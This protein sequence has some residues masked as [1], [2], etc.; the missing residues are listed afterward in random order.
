MAVALGLLG[1]S[2]S[3]PPTVDEPLPPTPPPT[4]P[5][6]VMPAGRLVQST[7]RGPVSHTTQKGWRTLIQDGVV[8]IRPPEGGAYPDLQ[9]VSQGMREL[10]GAQDLRAWEGERRSLLLPGGAKI[11]MYGQAGQISRVSLYDGEESHEIDVLTQ[12]LLHSQVDAAV[13]SRRDGEEADGETGHLVLSLT[14]EDPSQPA[15]SVLYLAHVYVQQADASGQPLAEEIAPR[16]LGRQLPAAV[17][18]YAD[19]APVFPTE[20]DAVCDAIPQARGGLFQDAPGAPLEYTSRS[21]LWVV[22]IDGHKVTVTRRVDGLPK[23]TWED[24]GDPHENLNG[25]HIKDWQGNRRTLWLDDGTRITLH[26]DGPQEVVHTT[27]IYDGAQSHE[28]GNVGNQIRHSCVNA[29]VAAG[30]DA[31]EADGETAFLALLRGPTSVGGAVFVENIYL[32]TEEGGVTQRTYEAL[33]LA[34]TGDL[35][36]DRTLV[37]D[38]YDDPNL[39]AT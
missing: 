30:R 11:M 39:V 16:P 23:A 27:S 19:L 12:T 34:E 14:K 13:A 17:H 8:T 25:K 15:F 33:P 22:R 5:A 38:L 10:L 21:G 28:I 24:W 7:L 32:E 9:Y 20:T 35:E 36:T 37:M 18:V 26:A 4:P 31:Q 3:H 2:G 1:C 6:Q 29:Q